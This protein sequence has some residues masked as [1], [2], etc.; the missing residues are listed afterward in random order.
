MLSE[1][2]IDN[3][4][5]FT[6]LV[7]IAKDALDGKAYTPKT[8]NAKKEETVNWQ[9]L[10][11]GVMKLNWETRTSVSFSTFSFKSFLKIHIL[12]NLLV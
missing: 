6:N 7:I 12:L 3:K 2:A 1:L 11:Y 8:V 4:E 10:G 5:A 9:I